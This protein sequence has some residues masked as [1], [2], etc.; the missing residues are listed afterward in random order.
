MRTFSSYMTVFIGAGLG[1]LLRHGVNRAAVQAGTTFPWHTLA[2]NVT[3]S[4]AIGLLA[5]WFAFRGESAQTLQLFLV[6]GLLGGYTT[7]SAFSLETLLLW[8]RG[9][10][11]DAVFYVACS[12]ALSLAAAAM[13]LVIIRRLG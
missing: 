11:W 12:V 9:H 1:G 7:F 6:T 10:G 4:F 13:G 8:E 3:G 2:V 5:G